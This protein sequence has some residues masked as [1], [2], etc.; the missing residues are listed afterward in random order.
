V[1]LPDDRYPQSYEAIPAGKDVR[2]PIPL[3][4]DNTQA[5]EKLGF[6]VVPVGFADGEYPTPPQ[7]FNEPF[8]IPEE[9]GGDGG[10]FS[11]RGKKAATK[12]YFKNAGEKAFGSRVKPVPEIPEDMRIEGAGIDDPNGLKS[13]ANHDD[14]AA[15]FFI[16]GALGFIKLTMYKHAPN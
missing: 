3:E 7:T 16:K 11:L 14:V 5:N 15:V 4:M 13:S 9:F 6:A 12:K 2:L 1:V 8:P 10:S